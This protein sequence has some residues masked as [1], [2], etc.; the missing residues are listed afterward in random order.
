MKAIKQYILRLFKPVKS[1]LI[2]I[3]RSDGWTLIYRENGNVVKVESSKSN[4]WS[5]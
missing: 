4:Y 3:Q 2:K 5:R 1:E